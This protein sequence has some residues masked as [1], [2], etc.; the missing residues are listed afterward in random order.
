MKWYHGFAMISNFIFEKKILDM[1]ISMN[2]LDIIS[3]PVYI[4]TSQKP[5]SYRASTSASFIQSVAV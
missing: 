3:L 2:K 4:K 5:N 1:Y